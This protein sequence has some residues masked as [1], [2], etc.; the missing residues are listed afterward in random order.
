MFT[1]RIKQLNKSSE[2]NIGMRSSLSGQSKKPWPNVRCVQ[3]LHS[4]S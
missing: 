3:H 4:S 2:F 1:Y